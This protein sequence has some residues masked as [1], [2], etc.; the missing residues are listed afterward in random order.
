MTETQIALLIGFVAV[1][2]AGGVVTYV[3]SLRT[4]RRKR[5]LN[6][7]DFGDEAGNRPIEL[8]AEET[9]FR[10]ANSEAEEAGRWQ[11]FRLKLDRRYALIGG[12]PTVRRAAYIAAGGSVA[13]AIGIIG[14]TPLDPLQAAP[15]AIVAAAVIALFCLQYAVSKKMQRFVDLFPDAVDLVVRGIRAGLPVPQAIDSIA[16]EIPDP[17]GTE[18][19]QVSDKLKIGVPMQESLLEATLRIPIAE[20]KFFAVT[21]ILQRE[22]GGQLAEV[23]ENLSDILRKRRGMKLKI[24]ALTSEARAASKIVA[25]IPFLAGFGLYYINPDQMRL[26]IDDPSGQNLLIYCAVSLALGLGIIRTMS[27]IEA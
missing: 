4:E 16:N 9:L 21:L 13:I 15:V 8:E 7:M 17:I 27:R 10:D 14:N 18:F 19:R 23:L 3:Y 22:T 1:L 20:V 6:R 12:F 26:L 24:K 11:V 2:I 25:A 5:L